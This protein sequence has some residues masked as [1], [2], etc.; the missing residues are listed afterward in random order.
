[1]SEKLA[2]KTSEAARM[3][4]VSEIWLKKDRRSECP[5][6]PPAIKRGRMVLYR[7]EDLEKWLTQ[8]E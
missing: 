7:V 2:V 3:I 1:M 5:I 8:G 4:G 6:G